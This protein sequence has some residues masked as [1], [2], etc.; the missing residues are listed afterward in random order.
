[1]ADHDLTTFR[2]RGDVG[3]GG[4]SLDILFDPV[5]GGDALHSLGGDRRLVRLHQIKVCFR[6]GCVTP[7]ASDC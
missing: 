4:D 5:K 1:M 3:V 7:S 6:Q 2:E